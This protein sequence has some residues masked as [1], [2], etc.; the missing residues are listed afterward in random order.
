MLGI[1]CNG[2][3]DLVVLKHQ[4]VDD[5]LPSPE[6]W[7]KWDFTSPG[8]FNDEC[9]VM[10]AN[11]IRDSSSSMTYSCTNLT[12]GIMVSYSYE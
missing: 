9:F 10:D 5:N 7:S 6:S 3:E 8:N 4:E 1:H 12:S 11:S 2:M